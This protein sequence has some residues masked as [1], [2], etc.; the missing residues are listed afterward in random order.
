MDSRRY[1]IVAGTL[2]RGLDEHGRL[3]FKEAVLVVVFAGDARNIVTHTN[4]VL[5]LGTAQV[6]IAM[7][8]RDVV[9]HLFA[10]AN[11]KGRGLSGGK[12]LEGGHEH[13]HLARGKI[14]IDRPLTTRA[15]HTVRRHNELGTATECLVEDVLVAVAVKGELNDTRSVAQVNENEGTEVTLTLYPTHHTYFFSNIALAK[16]GTV[17]CSF[18]LFV[19]KFCHFIFSC[20]VGFRNCGGGMYGKL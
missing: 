6:Q 12:H 7:A 19:Q 11:L 4:V 8:K 15:N 3:D 14:G 18:V 1:H 13:L 9:A 17:V 16:F 20:L 2:G 10:R 5:K